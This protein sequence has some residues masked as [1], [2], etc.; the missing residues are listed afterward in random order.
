MLKYMLKVCADGVCGWYVLMVC[1][2]GML[3]GEVHDEM[4]ECANVLSVCGREHEKK[5]ADGARKPSFY[6]NP[7]T[8]AVTPPDLF[9]P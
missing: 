9:F 5:T 7:D 3:R 2:D 1:A 4:K 8:R 6:R